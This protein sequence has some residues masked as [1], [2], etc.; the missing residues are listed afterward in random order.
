MKKLITIIGVLAFTGIAQAQSESWFYNSEAEYKANVE[1]Q[2]PGD[3]GLGGDDPLPA[4]IDDYIPL[5]LI[6]GLGMAVWYARQTQTET[7]SA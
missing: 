5:L 2:S 7:N 4:P 3:G 1:A 6:A